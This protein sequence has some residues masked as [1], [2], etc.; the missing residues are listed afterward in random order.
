VLPVTVGSQFILKL[1][2]SQNWCQGTRSQDSLAH[3]VVQGE[4]YAFT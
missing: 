4:G 2:S 3:F 1:F